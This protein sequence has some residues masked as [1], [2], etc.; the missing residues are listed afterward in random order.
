MKNFIDW[1]RDELN[2][3][4]LVTG[5]LATWLVMTGAGALI[6]FLSILI[7]LLLAGA[8]GSIILIWI[9]AP[10][11]VVVIAYILRSRGK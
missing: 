10:V 11:L 8:W 9:G 4:G 7:D 2:H 5:A 1:L 6:A 3:K